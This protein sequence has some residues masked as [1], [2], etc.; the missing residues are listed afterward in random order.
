M[1]ISTTLVNDEFS[2]IYGSSVVPL[3][4][5]ATFK[6]L[7]YMENK[8]DYTRS[9]NPTRDVLEKKMAELEFG[10]KA[11]AFTSGMAALSVV[12]R[13]V[14]HGE[15]I[16]CSN[17]SYGGTY[18]LLQKIVKR[19][20]IRI[21]YVDL[22]GSNGIQNLIRSIT[23]ITKLIMIESP[24]NPFQRICDIRKISQI[25]HKYNVLVS[26][27]NT[28]LSPL[29]Q[30]PLNLGCDIVCHS[31]TKFL[32]GHSDCMAGVIIVKDHKLAK[33]IYF[34]QNAEGGALAPFDCWLLLRGIKTLSLRIYKQQDNAIK[35]CNFLEKNT[36]VRKIYY[37]GLKSHDNYDLHMSQATGG[38][39][40]ISFC[41]GDT[42]L[43]RHV[44]KN[45]KLF[46]TTVSFG[47]IDSRIEMPVIMSHAS[48]PEDIRN[49]RNFPECT[50]RI[51]IG[52]EDVS[53]LISD[54]NFAFD[55]FVN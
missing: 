55:T 18:R 9:G 53:D 41:T 3:Y 4:Q 11:F 10:N 17:D 14:K 46:K 37:C 7:S 19:Q 8:Y 49:I 45:T 48:I 32:S 31:A 42:K 50:I 36:L 1:K 34:Y 38:G 40:V 22:E 15:E 21:K 47:S 51:S 35:I 6:Q 33:E 30:N 16:I 28:M 12:T 44:V 27:D 39:S 52:I 29:L 13:L 25:A 23:K 2:D 24:T 26:V 54:L 5:T 20:G 43:S